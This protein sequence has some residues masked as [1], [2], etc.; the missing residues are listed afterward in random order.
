MS[1]QQNLITKLYDSIVYHIHTPVDKISFPLVSNYVL[2]FG[3]KI[4]KKQPDD[5]KLFVLKEVFRLLA[6]SLPISNPD[7]RDDLIQMTDFLAEA[8]VRVLN[9]YYVKK[10]CLA[11]CGK[12]AE[13]E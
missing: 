13:E 2:M 10:P 12:K 6:E 1:K 8:L 11:W 4:L 3:K 7:H 9:E 5:I